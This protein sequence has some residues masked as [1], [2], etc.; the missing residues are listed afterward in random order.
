MALT[1]IVGVGFEW[2][3]CCFIRIWLPLPVAQENKAHLAHST[4]LDLEECT[5]V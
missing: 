4:S 5:V 3:C 2:N 1:S